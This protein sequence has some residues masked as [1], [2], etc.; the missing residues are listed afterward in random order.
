MARVLKAVA[1]GPALAALLVF[2]A[3]YAAFMNAGPIYNVSY[4]IIYCIHTTPALIISAAVTIRCVAW[5]IAGHGKSGRVG[6]WFNSSLAVISFGLVMSGLMG[7]YGRAVITEGQTFEGRQWWMGEGASTAVRRFSLPPDINLALDRVKDAG[8]SGPVEA[9]FIDVKDQGRFNA[10]SSRP[11]FKGGAVIVITAQGYSPHFML[12]SGDG[13][14]VLEDAYV[15]LDILPFGREDSFS[16]LL[17]FTYYL[18]SVDG[19]KLRVRVA[20]NKLLIADKIAGPGEPVAFEGVAVRFPDM[21]RWVEVAVY[22]DYGLIIAVIGLLSL[23][24]SSAV[25][26]SK[27]LKRKS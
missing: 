21:R 15:Y 22:K 10:R 25:W 4:G 3:V 1:S 19:A 18:S 12:T 27:L 9:E 26:L 23:I 6:I 13:G 2:A 8:K 11:A 14:R 24:A 16:T 5:F 7:F 17:P 20:K